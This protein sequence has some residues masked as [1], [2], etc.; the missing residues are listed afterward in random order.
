[1]DLDTH[2]VLARGTEAHLTPYEFRILE[3]LMRRPR[4]VFS[5]EHI[6]NQ[7]SEGGFYGSPKTLDVHIRHLREKIEEDPANPRY[8][9]TVRGAGYRLDKPSEA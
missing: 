5:R 8:I 3:V 6:L 7:V 9:R 2:E 4:R 1:M